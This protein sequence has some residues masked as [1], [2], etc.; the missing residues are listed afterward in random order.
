M[1]MY[2]LLSAAMAQS[3]PAGVEAVPGEYIIKL[4]STRAAQT[5]QQKVSGKLSFKGQVSKS[6]VYHLQLEKAQDFQALSNDPDVE[7]IEPNYILSKPT[8]PEQ[9]EQK[10]FSESDIAAMASTDFQQNYANVR[11][12]QAW[13]ILSPYS[14]TNVPVVAV[15][16]TGI[17]LNHTVFTES[18]SLWRNQA[19][20]AGVPGVDDDFNGYVDDINGWNFYANTNSPADD[21]GHGTH[22]AGIV[23]GTGLDIFASPRDQSRIKIMPLKF[24]TPTGGRTSD[25]IR[26]IYYAVDNGAQVINCSW[27]GGSYSQALLDAFTYAYNHE[28]LV[29]T[30]AGNS[31]RNNDDYPMWPSSYNVPSNLSVASSTDSDAMSSFSNYGAASVHV[32]S[33]GSSIYSTYPTGS[34][35]IMS[36]TSMAAPFVAGIAALA[37]REAPQLTGYQVKQLVMSSVNTMS[38]F[39]NR[40]S[41]NGRVN[42][43]SLAVLAQSASGV[44]SSQPAYAPT[45][46]SMDLASESSS[47]GAPGGCGLVQAISASGGGGGMAGAIAVVFAFMLPLAVW[48]TYRLKSPAFR[49]RYERFNVNSD[50]RINL[51]GREIS[52][53]M[54][55]LSVGGL[56]FSAEDLIEKG[57]LVTMKIASPTGEG[58]IEVQGRIVWSEEKKAYGVQFQDASQ[59]IVDRITSWTKSLGRNAA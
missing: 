42:F 35:T 44:S 54:K 1:L 17:D 46:S 40:V 26:A 50:I 29:V 53:Q 49:R 27:G 15:V 57:S 55:T 56:S 38:A 20:L 8:N 32:A 33:P 2:W 6:G 13:S 24:L 21:D 41:T 28:V 12:E 23:V 19:E 5:L 45:Y 25:A 58:E 48:M 59:G 51:G 11:V 36:G 14:S 7:Y 52:G 30:A 4:K 34:Y 37:W 16:D 43:Y 9:G 31:S 3:F 47:S 10:V 18:Q 22:V 39:T